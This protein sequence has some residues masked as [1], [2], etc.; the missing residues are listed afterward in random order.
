[1]KY[2]NKVK[3]VGNL[4]KF[5]N[6]SSRDVDLYLTLITHNDRYRFL[7]P[8]RDIIDDDKKFLEILDLF[9]RCSVW[10]PDRNRTYRCLEKAATYNYLKDRNFSPSAYKTVAKQIDRR[11]TQTKSLMTTLEASME[12]RER[13]IKTATNKVKKE[14][15]SR[16]EGLDS[17]SS[18][19]FDF[20]EDE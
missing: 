7:L 13:N 15:E 12:H 17:I 19:D 1:M 10:F 2:G 11:I 20:T 6:I 14:L 18:Y 8:L 9:A 16:N 4:L 5:K 3:P